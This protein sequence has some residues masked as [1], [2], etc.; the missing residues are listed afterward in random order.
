MNKDSGPRGPDLDKLHGTVPSIVLYP[1]GTTYGVVINSFHIEERRDSTV[2]AQSYTDDM[3]AGVDMHGVFEDSDEE[4]TPDVTTPTERSHAS[5]L[6]S[7]DE[8]NSINVLRQWASL[9]PDVFTSASIDG[10]RSSISATLNMLGRHRRGVELQACKVNS[11]DESC[12]NRGI[13]LMPTIAEEDEDAENSNQGAPLAT[14]APS[15]PPAFP[16]PPAPS[17]APAPSAEDVRNANSARQPQRLLVNKQGIV[18]MPSVIE[19][20]DEDTEDEDAW[21]E[22]ED[23]EFEDDDLESL[24]SS[25]WD[26]VPESNDPDR[27]W[28]LGRALI[29][30]E[31]WDGERTRSILSMGGPGYDFYCDPERYRDIHRYR[32]DMRQWHEINAQ[33]ALQRA[34]RNDPTSTYFVLVPEYF[35][36]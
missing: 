35:S 33:V 25:F 10:A 30:T 7:I 6:R 22:D 4:S 27:D 32:E 26:D 13:E 24:G 18:P 17:G 20:E 9:A 3:L 15:A 8:I 5:D 14:R 34:Y 28:I 2:L 12:R 16:A 36:S 19:A 29:Y 11:D 21:Y 23:S 31:L 1:P